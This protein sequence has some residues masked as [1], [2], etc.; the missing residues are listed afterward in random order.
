MLSLRQ[1]H[2]RYCAAVG[3]TVRSYVTVRA[4]RSRSNA[5]L[6][7]VLLMQGEAITVVVSATKL[8][9]AR[10][11]SLPYTTAALLKGPFTPL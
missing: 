4:Q 9:H 11:T 6:A 3:S 8:L 10:S 7:A 1:L 5:N 2:P